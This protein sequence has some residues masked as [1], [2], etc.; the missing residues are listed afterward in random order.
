MDNY[1]DINHKGPEDMDDE[2]GTPLCFASTPQLIDAL[3]DRFSSF[4]LVGTLPGKRGEELQH[5][6]FFKGDPAS[7]LGLVA[8]AEL[9]IKSTVL[10]TDTQG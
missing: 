5:G 2:D 6:R 1:F 8:L 9:Y 10:K 4:V 7:L 3:R